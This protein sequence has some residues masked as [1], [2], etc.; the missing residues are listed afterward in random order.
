[1]PNNHFDDHGF[2][3]AIVDQQI[4]INVSRSFG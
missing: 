2:I 4:S 1:L 3:K